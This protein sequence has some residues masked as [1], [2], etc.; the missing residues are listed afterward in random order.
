MDWW[1]S[2]GPG[3]GPGLGPS[4]H[5]YGQH[6]YATAATAAYEPHWA[7]APACPYG[8]APGYGPFCCPP[9]G[10]HHPAGRGYEYELGPFEAVGR[11]SSVPPPAGPRPP[12][13]PRLSRKGVRA[14]S[15]APQGPQGGCRSASPGRLRSASP[16]S[17]PPP[18]PP[19]FQPPPPPPVQPQAPIDAWHDGP[20]RP[21]PVPPPRR[22]SVSRYTVRG[23]AWRGVRLT[24]PPSYLPLTHLIYQSRVCCRVPN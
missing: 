4:Q 9:A 3:L 20:L 12:P 21:P 14:P 16:L 1:P 22:G 2:L 11:V 18:G 6:P 24:H 7:P 17:A 23:V 19:P 8:H 10:G 13:S 15:P 5:P